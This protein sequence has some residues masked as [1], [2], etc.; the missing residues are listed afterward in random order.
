MP[1][2]TSIHFQAL[3]GH[4]NRSCD[5]CEVLEAW[6]L[7]RSHLQ[8]R[9]LQECAV[10]VRTTDSCAVCG[11]ACEAAGHKTTCTSDAEVLSMLVPCRWQRASSGYEAR[12]SSIQSWCLLGTVITGTLVT[13]MWL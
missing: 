11:D 1:R 7:C 6:P 2:F 5:K 9:E 3:T 12:G 4:V 10:L 8:R 13:F